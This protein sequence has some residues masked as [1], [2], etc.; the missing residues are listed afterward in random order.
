MTR[1]FL[2]TGEQERYSEARLDAVRALARLAADEGCAFAVVCG[3]VFDSNLVDRSVVVRALDA[4]GAFE[5]PV[6]LLPANHD[7]LNAAS[8]YRSRAWLEHCPAH[9]VVLESADPVA[10]ADVAAEVVGAPWDSKQPLEDLAARACAGLPPRPTPG[11]ARILVAHGAV[12]TLSPDK[13]EPSLIRLVAAEKAIADGVADYIALGDRHSVTQVGAT[14][15]IWYSGTPLVT[16]YTEDAPNEVLVVSLE[17]GGRCD[18]A[19]HRVGGWRFVRESFP[20]DGAEGVD[21]VQA[22]LEGLPAKRETVVKLSFQGTV[23]L[24]EK[25]RLDTLLAH[26]DDLFAALET[27]E[28]H[29]D[30][31]VKPDDADLR[32]L[33][34]SGFAAAAL[35]DL[36]AEAE[37][38]GDAGQTAQDALGLLYRLARSGA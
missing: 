21:A 22:Y 12:D 33:G 9:V 31:V 18:V 23:S 13:D 15:R 10:V 17:A 2:S 11:T 1:H 3:D 24:A 30:L 26:Y 16:D 14:G 29:T 5:V 34:L 7:P 28:R 8:V 27:W 38:G 36:R 6:F 19:R 35:D 37:A 4:L 20:V 32:D 25:A